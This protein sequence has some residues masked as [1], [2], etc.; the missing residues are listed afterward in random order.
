LPDKLTSKPWVIPN[1]SIVKV[2]IS[3]AK[4]G[5]QKNPKISHGLPDDCPSPLC[6]PALFLFDHLILKANATTN[7]NNNKPTTTTANNNK[8]QQQQPNPNHTTWTGRR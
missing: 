6:M 5:W 4:R 1:Y 8:R 3:H 2:K 7:A